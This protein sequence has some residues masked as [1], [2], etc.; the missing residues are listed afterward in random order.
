MESEWIRGFCTSD[1]L[2]NDS[3]SIFKV[4][5]LKE[6]NNGVG[7]RDSGASRADIAR[8][9][10]FEHIITLFLNVADK[11]LMVHF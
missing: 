7:W 6:G 11:K 8:V 3:S 1:G 10:S 5:T 9:G 2:S 4:N